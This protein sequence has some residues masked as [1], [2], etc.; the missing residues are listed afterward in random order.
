MGQPLIEGRHHNACYASHMRASAH[1]VATLIALC[2]VQS[3]SFA[4]GWTDPAPAVVSLSAVQGRAPLTV[5]VT[6]PQKFCEKF[7]KWDGRYGFGNPGWWIDWG[8]GASQPGDMTEKRRPGPLGTHTYTVAG[9]YK[10]SASI[11]HLD[12]ADRP[13]HDW[14]GENTV[15]VYPSAGA[16]QKPAAVAQTGVALDVLAPSGGTYTYQVFPDV[17]WKLATDRAIK[18]KVD[19]VDQQNNVIANGVQKEIAYNQP[20]EEAS[21]QCPAF[22]TYDRALLAGKT[23]FRYVVTAAAVDGSLQTTKSSPW[24][25]MTREYVPI[26]DPLHVVSNTPAAGGSATVVLGYLVNHPKRFSYILD[27]GDGSK[28]DQGATNGSTLLVREIKKFTHTYLQ[29]GA[30]KVILRSNNGDPYKKVEDIPFFESVTVR[31][32]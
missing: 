2:L 31:V 19:L 29:P 8:D 3:V 23:T 7:L 12:Y 21:F 16:V 10:V 30:Y 13:R 4:Q 1:T 26:S 11:V 25:K 20:S 28:P 14:I 27:W 9:T 32:K 24:F 17:K 15:T 6:G 18:L 22:E 5:R